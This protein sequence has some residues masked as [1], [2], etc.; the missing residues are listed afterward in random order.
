MV[1]LKIPFQ[2]KS[3]TLYFAAL[4]QSSSKRKKLRDSNYEWLD[5]VGLDDFYLKEV[6]IS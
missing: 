3:K 6:K 5:H 1:D 2:N 4:E